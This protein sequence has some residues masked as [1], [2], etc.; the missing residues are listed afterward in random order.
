MPL[1]RRGGR[2]K[3]PDY[4]PA[5]MRS[6]WYVARI[7]NYRV[8]RYKIGPPICVLLSMIH[9][10]WKKTTL[11]KNQHDC[12]IIVKE[13]KVQM[14]R[15]PQGEFGNIC[16]WL[17]RREHR[18]LHWGTDP[19]RDARRDDVCGQGERSTKEISLQGIF[20]LCKKYDGVTI[21]NVQKACMRPCK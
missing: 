17:P 15:S 4:S 5:E 9:T 16:Q 18:P 10:K 20:M 7:C 14:L 3:P 1:P 19:Q 13:T 12:S 21:S 2:S 6:S 11:I 8:L